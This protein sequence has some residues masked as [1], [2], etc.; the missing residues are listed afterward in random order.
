MRES[1]RVEILRKRP[2]EQAFLSI[3]ILMAARDA[4]GGTGAA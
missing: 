3:A 2:A 1:E 4:S